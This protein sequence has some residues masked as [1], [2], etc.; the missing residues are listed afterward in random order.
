LIALA[1]LLVVTGYGYDLRDQRDTAGLRIPLKSVGLRAPA[2]SL[3]FAVT[4]I[5]GLW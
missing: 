2:L 4:I 3:F 5:P 1:L